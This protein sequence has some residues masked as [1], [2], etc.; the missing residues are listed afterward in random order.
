[1]NDVKSQVNS[2]P[3]PVQRYFNHVLK[4]GQTF[5]SY[6]R[7]KHNGQF[8]PGFDKGW[9]NIKGEQYA[10]TEKPGFIWKGTTSMFV[11]RDMY[12]ADKGRLIVSL[13]GLYNIADASGEA[14]NQ[15]ELLRWLGESILYPTN[16]LPGQRLQW[17]AID[18]QTAKL[19]YNYC[20]LSLYFIVTFNETGE[21][22][23]MV[24]KR[25]ST[26]FQKTGPV[27]TIYW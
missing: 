2:L 20:G 12:I 19:T 9:M 26:Y 21:I 7:I 4:D 25:L 3:E 8:R 24:T 10:T 11:A 17:A 16:F 27:R 15:G 13:F 23:E 18:S 22:T 5:I 6:A 14:Y 1:V